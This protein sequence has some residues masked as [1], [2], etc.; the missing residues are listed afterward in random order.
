MQAFDQMWLETDVRDIL[1]AIQVPTLVICRKDENLDEAQWVSSQISGARLLPLSGYRRVVWM[2]D[3]D[4]LSEAVRT[5]LRTSREEQVAFDRVLATVLFTD[6]VDSTSQTAAM[7]DQAWRKVQ[8]AHDTIVRA[9]LTRYR[10]REIRTMG[11]GFLASFDGPGRAVRCAQAITAAM[12]PLGIEIRAGL[13]TGEI[14]LNGDDVGGIAVAIGARVGALAGP[15]EV[16]VSNTVKDL[17]AGSGL[18]FEDRGSHALKGLPN[19]WRLYA[20]RN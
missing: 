1:P 20:A 13:H 12:R 19:E 16:L 14:E 5:F 4:E 18:A 8:E 17:V 10:G 7:G 9:Q 2:G 3:L 15:S 6:I 11:D